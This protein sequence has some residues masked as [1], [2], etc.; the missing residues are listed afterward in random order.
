M[1]LNVWTST[2][3]FYSNQENSEC[4]PCMSLSPRVLL[5]FTRAQDALDSEKESDTSLNHSG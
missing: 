3:P 5:I 4:V 1:A 2:E